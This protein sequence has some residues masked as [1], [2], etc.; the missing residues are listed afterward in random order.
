MS[1]RT[2]YAALAWVVAVLARALVVR[3]R[4]AIEAS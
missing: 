2:T 3:R 1:S 4:R